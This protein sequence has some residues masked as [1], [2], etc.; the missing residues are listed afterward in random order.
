MSLGKLLE[1]SPRGRDWRW[2]GVLF[3]DVFRAIS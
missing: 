2:G 3:V 1:P